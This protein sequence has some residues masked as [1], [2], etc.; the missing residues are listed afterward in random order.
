MKLFSCES[1]QQSCGTVAN[2]RSSTDLNCAGSFRPNRNFCFDLGALDVK[3]GQFRM[4]DL[5]QAQ[6]RGGTSILRTAS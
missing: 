1:I 4:E 5:R 3:S 6:C 2:A